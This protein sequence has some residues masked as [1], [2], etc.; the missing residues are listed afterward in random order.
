MLISPEAN[1]CVNGVIL[2]L[3]GRV[4]Y[5]LFLL[6]MLFSLIVMVAISQSVVGL[7]CVCGG[8]VQM[9][10][11]IRVGAGPRK[12]SADKAVWLSINGDGSRTVQWGSFV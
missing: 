12:Q 5:T 4:E 7:E 8:E 10:G 1:M 9:D 3:S 6:P 2:A 11:S